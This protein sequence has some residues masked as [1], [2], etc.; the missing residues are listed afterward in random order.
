MVIILFKSNFTFCIITL[1]IKA[2]NLFS[3]QINIVNR[4]LKPENIL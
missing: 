4:D 3:F 1:G 2:S